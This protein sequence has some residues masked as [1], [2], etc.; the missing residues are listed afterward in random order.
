M[1]FS[2]FSSSRVRSLLLIDDAIKKWTTKRA[3][4]S[5]SGPGLALMFSEQT[6][7]TIPR[8]MRIAIAIIMLLVC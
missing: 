8:G 4:P 7:W 1:M 3:A 2:L 5:R 6:T